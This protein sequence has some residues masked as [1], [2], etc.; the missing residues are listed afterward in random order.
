MTTAI[1]AQDLTP[2]VLELAFSN[3]KKNEAANWIESQI[4]S[5]LHAIS[6]ICKL[7]YLQ[8][9]SDKATASFQTDRFIADFQHTF[10]KTPINAEIIA[11]FLKTRLPILASIYD[12]KDHEIIRSDN[13]FTVHQFVD[14]CFDKDL[15]LSEEEV[16][17][18]LSEHFSDSLDCDI[19][20]VTGLALS[21]LLSE[22]PNK[23]T[24]QGIADVLL[25]YHNNLK[26]EYEE[27]TSSVNWFIELSNDWDITYFEDGSVAEDPDM[28]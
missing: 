15:F 1:Y 3:F 6:G 25:S 23:N 13:N 9:D 27:K 18:Y 20:T 26:A 14:S 16:A 19:K 5:E 4:N 2:I 8:F 7:L 22:H 28:Q 21:H 24:I 10:G 17:Q 11:N 12:D